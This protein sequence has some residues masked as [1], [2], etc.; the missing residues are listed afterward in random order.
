MST[1]ATA[2]FT[3]DKWDE[4]PYLELEGGRKF[5]RASVRSSYHGAIE[6]ESTSESLMF[7]REDGTASYTG[8]EHVTGRLDG[9]AGSFILE[10]RGTF[11]NGVASTTF[12]IVPSSGTGELKGIRGGAKFEAGHANSYSLLLDYDLD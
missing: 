11:A 9:K 2:T 3:I 7:Y 5:T 4:Q 8:F 6:G 10:G 1:H 12:V